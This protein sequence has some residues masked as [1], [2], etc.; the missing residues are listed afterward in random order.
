MEAL[1]MEDAMG[2][3]ELSAGLEDAS[4]TL[5]ETGESFG[6][7]LEGCDS[8]PLIEVDG[9]LIPISGIL[10]QPFGAAEESDSGLGPYLE[11]LR[12]YPELRDPS[13]MPQDAINAIRSG[14]APVAAYQDYLLQQELEERAAQYREAA[15]VRCPGSATGVGN[16]EIDGA[17]AAFDA[18]L[19]GND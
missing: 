8:E 16:G 1:E 14:A 4:E 7:S 18:A 19:Y 11:L 15:R 5:E 6:T 17:F 2:G 9:E 3:E 13:R 12:H 10:E